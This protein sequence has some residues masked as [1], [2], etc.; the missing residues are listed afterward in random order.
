MCYLISRKLSRKLSPG[1]KRARVNSHLGMGLKSYAMF[2]KLLPFIR[3]SFELANLYQLG[4][5]ISDSVDGTRTQSFDML[6]K[7]QKA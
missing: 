1:F 7:L 5:N 2:N 3:R 4:T 6:S